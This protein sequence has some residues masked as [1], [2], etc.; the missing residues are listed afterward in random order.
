M[1]SCKD[2]LVTM[3]FL[4]AVCWSVS[5]KAQENKQPKNMLILTGAS[6]ASPENKWFELGCESMGAKAINRAVGGQSIAST[7][8][9]MVEGK[10]YSPEELEEMDALVIMQVHDRVVVGDSLLLPKYTDYKTP[11][12]YG[13]YVRAYDYVIKR[14]MAECYE[15][16][17]SPKSKYYNTKAGKPA[18]IV[19][20]TH[21]HD[22]RAIFN[23]SVRTLAAKWG[24]PLVEFD[25]YIG[26]SKNTPHPVTGE[27]HSLIFSDDT[28]TVGDVKYGWHPNRGR[29]KYIQQRMAAIFADQMNRILPIK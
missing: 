26:F 2:V 11:F 17:N 24:L 1:R 12:D 18:V 20:C 15:L 27:Q 9:M 22:G 29:D 21:W 19:L 8:N 4:L 7:A 6:F 10:L 14:Y 3:L 16:K 25:K 23:A 5:A 13:D 28:Q